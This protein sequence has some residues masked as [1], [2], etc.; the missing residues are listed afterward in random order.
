MC[1]EARQNPTRM[2]TK[3]EQ[4][5]NRGGSWVSAGVRSYASAHTKENKRRPRKDLRKTGE[6]AKKKQTSAASRQR[7][8]HVQRGHDPADFVRHVHETSTIRTRNER[9][10]K[11]CIELRRPHA[12][13]HMRLPCESFTIKAQVCYMYM[14]LRCESHTLKSIRGCAAKSTR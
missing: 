3:N 1:A 11:G 12:Q 6:E 13:V 2:K 9:N 7:A 10:M 4:Q 8:V 14:R 5:A